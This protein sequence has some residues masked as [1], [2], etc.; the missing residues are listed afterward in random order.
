MG[1]VANALHELRGAGASI[2]AMHKEQC[3]LMYRI[4]SLLA[5]MRDHMPLQEISTRIGVS[6]EDLSR[7]RRVA[8]DMSEPDF[9][10]FLEQLEHGTTWNKVARILLKQR[11]ADTGL[12]VQ[13][14]ALARR[15]MSGEYPSATSELHKIRTLVLQSVKRELREELPMA[16]CVMCNGPAP[17]SGHTV[18]ESD[19]LHSYPICESCKKARR[20]PNAGMVAKVWERLATTFA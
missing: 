9:L 13:V 1:E 18:I 12:V 2:G 7:A 5:V 8:E 17:D 14:R 20:T 15:A 3:I 6:K 19:D 4:G 16:P 10:A 11:P